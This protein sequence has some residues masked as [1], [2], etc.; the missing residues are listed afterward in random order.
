[1]ATCMGG[2]HFGIFCP[3]VR[4]CS[5]LG[6]N[7]QV[8]QLTTSKRMLTERASWG[9]VKNAGIPVSVPLNETF[10]CAKKMLTGCP[11]YWAGTDMLTPR[12]E[13]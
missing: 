4:P 9:L 7:S 5:A 12:N 8:I 6:G 2:E 3:L 10:T 13:L 11:L 1:V